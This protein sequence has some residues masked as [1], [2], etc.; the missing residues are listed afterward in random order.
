MQVQA[1]GIFEY[2]CDKRARELKTDFKYAR[3]VQEKIR[4][5]SLVNPV[6]YHWSNLILF[7]YPCGF[8][9][10]LRSICKQIEKVSF[11][12]THYAKRNARVT[13][14]FCASVT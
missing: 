7:L 6:L 9:L 2:E 3:W 10:Q 12:G 8:V 4:H 1:C 13:Y 14:S 11:T 5:L